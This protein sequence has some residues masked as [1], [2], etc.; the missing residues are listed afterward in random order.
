VVYSWGVLH[1]TGEM[2]KALDNARLAVADKGKLFIAIYN[3][4]GTKSVRWRS[5]KR[6]YNNLPRFLRSP[7]ALITILPEETK[8]I[9]RALVTLRPFEYVRSWTKYDENRGMNKWRDIIDWVGGY[10]YEVARPEEIFDFYRER[11]FSLM[12]M[13]CGGVGL[14]CNEF[15]FRKE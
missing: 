3:D 12:K 8:A 6:I 4:L 14:G 2:W 5:I 7:F 13:K 10:P 1:H 9:L 15:V 11:G